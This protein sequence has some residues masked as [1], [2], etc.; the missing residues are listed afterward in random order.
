MAEGF[1]S[2]LH[3]LDLFISQD[4]KTLEQLSQEPS[5]NEIHSQ[6]NEIQ[7]NINSYALY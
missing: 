4:H 5:N 7:E 2:V 6:I 3:F 1:N